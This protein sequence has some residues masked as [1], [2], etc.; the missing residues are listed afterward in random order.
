MI[1]DVREVCKTPFVVSHPV[2]IFACLCPGKNEML[3]HLH[4]DLFNFIS[5]IIND[6]VH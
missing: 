1:D 3:C 2:H 5:Q 4:I 6:A